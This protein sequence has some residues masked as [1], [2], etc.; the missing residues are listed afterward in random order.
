M[1]T[2]LQGGKL[3]IAAH[4]LLDVILKNFLKTLSQFYGL[5]CTQ[6]ITLGSKC[7]V[8]R[9]KPTNWHTLHLVSI[10]AY[11]ATFPLF[12][13]WRYSWQSDERAFRD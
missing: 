13:K 12:E 8:F 11:T 10:I 9:I 6:I 5:A 7:S 3:W 2:N 4:A 1:T